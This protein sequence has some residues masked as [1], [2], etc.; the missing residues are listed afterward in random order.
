[1]RTERRGPRGRQRAV[2]CYISSLSVDADA[3]LALVR[4][5]RGVENSLHRTLDV[6]FRED[7]CCLRTGYGPP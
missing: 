6:Q 4:G 1:M 2:R 5:H 3:L 7:D